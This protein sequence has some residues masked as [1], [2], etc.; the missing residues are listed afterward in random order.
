MQL[1][2]NNNETTESSLEN[3]LVDDS[4]HMFGDIALLM[5]YFPHTIE[6]LKN[7]YMFIGDIGASSHSSQYQKEMVNIHDEQDGDS[8]MVDSE[9][10]VKANKI[11][12]IMGKVCDNR[13]T[14][15]RK[16]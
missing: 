9:A 12:N 7:Y 8:I 1:E 11:R 15:L 14:V 6:A 13:S 5:T 2:I 3:K 4:I 16:G 10:V